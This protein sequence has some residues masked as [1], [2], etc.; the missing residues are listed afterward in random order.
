MKEQKDQN[1][2]LNIIDSEKDNI[3]QKIIIINMREIKVKNLVDLKF[4]EE[5]V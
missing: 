2:T 4:I 1:I 5:N 3:Q